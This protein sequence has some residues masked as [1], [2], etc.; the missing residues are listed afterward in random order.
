MEN[1]QKI[2]KI[3]QIL[4]KNGRHWKASFF[5]YEG[6]NVNAAIVGSG[7]YSDFAQNFSAAFGDEALTRGGQVLKLV[8]EYPDTTIAVSLCGL[9]VA[10]PAIHKGVEAL[11]GNHHTINVIDSA[12]LGSSAAILAYAVG[13]DTSL[14]TTSAAGFITAQSTLAFSH[15]N[16]F[17]MKAGGLMLAFGGAALAAFG[18]DSAMTT[19]S[20]PDGIETL[21]VAMDVATVATGVS[22]I[23]AS[24]VTYEGGVLNSEALPDDK[25]ELKTWVSKVTHP[26]RG[27]L[28]KF[29]K[30]SV[31]RPVI[32]SSNWAKRNLL[33]Y[34]PNRIKET[35]P[36][37]TA[38]WARG[39]LRAL[40]G[41]L[42]VLT[43][44]YAF[45]ASYGGWFA[46]DYAMGLEDDRPKPVQ[47]YSSVAD[48]LG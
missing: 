14:I 47:E 4:T 12:V 22:V 43:G 38:L 30:E 3:K 21:R 41:A 16:P 27:A 8:S 1:T 18:V 11:G 39:P 48:A 33:F 19:F 31:D 5:L 29:F 46:G 26:H 20:S 45:A 24:G 35:K 25:K 13:A 40:T 15:E 17:F 23:V 6:S 44:E 10:G 32:A 28:A 7:G 36:L 2:S 37:K 9:V 34:V 42:A